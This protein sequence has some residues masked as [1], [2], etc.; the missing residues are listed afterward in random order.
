M[1]AVQRGHDLE[2]MT[3]KYKNVQNL[4][5]T[6][7]NSVFDMTSICVLIDMTNADTDKQ[8]NKIQQGSKFCG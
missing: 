1:P 5:F 6:S 8:M 7:F 2:Y 4:F 3:L